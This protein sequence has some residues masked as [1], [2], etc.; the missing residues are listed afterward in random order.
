[1]RIRT[2]LE[3]RGQLGENRGWFPDNGDVVFSHRKGL[4][5]V[6]HVVVCKDDGT[7]VYDQF[8][9]AEPVG[10][11]TVPVNSK[12]EFGVIDVW[13]PTIV[14]AEEYRFPDLDLAKVGVMSTE[15][16]RGFPKKGEVG[17][18]TA[19]REA[20]EELS[21]P[22]R[23]VAQIGE[24][25]PN[26]TFHP[27]RIPVF[28]AWLDEAR[29]ADV[30]AKRTVPSPDMNEKILNVRWVALDHLFALMRERKLH[31]GATQAAL[32]LYLAAYGNVEVK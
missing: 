27:H 20:Q 31:C 13:R 16:P 21:S 11:V 23:K 26:T 28:A 24:W 30:V 18:Q 12:G 32:C 4:G 14:S 25:T 1:M 2:F 7:P 10:A 3:V 29:A 22:I 17:A 15:F 19:L 8:I 6:R 9:H 5:V